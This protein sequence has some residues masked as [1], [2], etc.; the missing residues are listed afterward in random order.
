MTKQKILKPQPG[1]QEAFLSTEADVCVYGGAAGGGKTFAIL[2]DPLRHLEDPNYKCVIFRRTSPQITAPGSLWDE[3]RKMYSIE[4]IDGI[5]REKDLKYTFP[6]G[7][8]VKFAHMEHEKDKINWQGTQITA[9]FFD[10]GTH[11]TRT[12][13]TYMFSRL[14]SES[15]R[16]GY[17]RITCNPDPDSF[18]REWIDWYLED[19]LPD[20]A[21]SGVIRYF[22]MMGDDMIWEGEDGISS[23]ES[24]MKSYGEMIDHDESLIMS[25]TFIPATLADNPAML[26]NN[27]RYKASLMAM[28]RIDRERLLGGNWD[29][30]ASAGEYFN[31]EWVDVVP[32][33][34]VPKRLKLLRYWDRAATEP[35]ETNK[36]PDWT[37]G[38]LMGRCSEGYTWVIDVD[39]FRGTP[40]KVKK[41]I[42]ENALVDV[43]GTRICIEQDPGAAGKSEAQDVVEMLSGYD[44]RKRP[45]TKAKLTR[46]LPFSAAAENG[47]VKVV[48]AVWNEDFFKELE[49]FVG[50]DTG[51]DDQVDTCSGGYIEFEEHFKI[52]AFEM[53]TT[54]LGKSNMFRIQ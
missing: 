53:D 16:N 22:I 24:L 35:N 27:P 32:R 9:A 37:V 7:M 29:V 45:A 33:Y 2:L 13:V 30:R 11:F 21:K 8:E 18:I 15:E 1:A 50:D 5:A 47:M 14:R 19:G 34:Q 48:K 31:R 10:E 12:M 6:S 38:T 28:N 46:F 20:P 36:N 43:N 17:I 41:R 51:K 3:A 25:F 52:P 40:K 26:A 42:K 49:N 4:G 23:R 54:G 44:A 39:R